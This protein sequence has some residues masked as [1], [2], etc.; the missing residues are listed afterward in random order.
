MP[1]ITFWSVMT[2][3]IR[4][5]LPANSPARSSVLTSSASGPSAR[6][7]GVPA[8]STLPTMTMRWPASARPSVAVTESWCV[9]RRDGRSGPSGPLRRHGTAISTRP[10]N[11]SRWSAP[12]PPPPTTS[13][14]CLNR[15]R[16]S[17]SS[18]RHRAAS[19]PEYH[20]GRHAPNAGYVAA[21]GLSIQRSPGRRRRSTR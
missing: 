4:P 18:P 1:A 14:G 17:R 9:S 10:A 21:P 5:V 8:T 6:G 16:R 11:A 7:C 12:M 19:S 2:V 13:A 20:C 3:L 15:R